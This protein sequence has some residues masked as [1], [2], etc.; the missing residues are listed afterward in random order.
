ML[1]LLGW[2]GLSWIGC[3]LG[4]VRW[5]GLV[6]MDL[7]GLDGLGWIGWIEL[8]WMDLVWV[9]LGFMDLQAM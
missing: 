5:I 9:E 7:V 3:G 2:I 4:W 6:W 8:G 1:L